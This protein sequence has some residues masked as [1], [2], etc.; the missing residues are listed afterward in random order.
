M[1]I[2]ISNHN[3]IQEIQI[4]LFNAFILLFLHIILVVKLFFKDF[5]QKMY[6][7]YLLQGVAVVEINYQNSKMKIKHI[8]LLA[9]IQIPFIIKFALFDL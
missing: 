3:Y 7:A 4:L 9:F 2:I 1:L 6:H 5:L 8:Y